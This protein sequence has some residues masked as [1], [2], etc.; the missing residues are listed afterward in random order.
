MS[1]RK[2]S[3]GSALN[4]LFGGGVNP[5]GSPSI[6]DGQQLVLQTGD[7]L[8]LDI[9]SV[10]PDP[11]QPRDL[12]SADLYESLFSGVLSA[13]DVLKRWMRSAE[14]GNSAE[15]QTLTELKQLAQTIAM[16]GLINPITVRPVENDNVPA[17]VSYLVRTGERR[18]WSHILLI[19]EQRKIKDRQS[20]ERI[21]ALIDTD[22]T[23]LRA[24]Q[25]V[26]NMARSD[27]SVIEKARGIDALRQEMRAQRNGPV[28]WEEIELLLG[29]SR[30][31]RWRLGKVLDLPAIAVD[32]I[33]RHNLPERSLRPIIDK[34]AGNGDL[35]I[36]AVERLSVWQEA[37]EDTGHKRMSAYIEALLRDSTVKSGV[38]S[39]S[40]SKWSTKFGRTL[41]KTLKLV[42]QLD[43]D[44]LAGYAAIVANDRKSAEYLSR[45]RDHINYILAESETLSG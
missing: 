18:W 15:K 13:T 2:K 10:M 35:Q 3:R 45:L 34:L 30:N 29:I 27:L 6:E 19:V 25:L 21:R 9:T 20:P 33:A 36:K 1:K 40:L 28:R 38:Q 39:D 23:N 11:K 31:Y 24:E 5:Y 41:N 22:T 43:S 42:D 26:E 32:L 8:E 17:T 37:D 12:L 4:N 16:H 44:Q 14:N 7:L